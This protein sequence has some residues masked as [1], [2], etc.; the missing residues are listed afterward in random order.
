MQGLT[1][2][3][4]YQVN[5]MNFVKYNPPANVSDKEQCCVRLFQ[6]W[7]SRANVGLECLVLSTHSA[8]SGLLQALSVIFVLST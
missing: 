7:E 3:G 5:L 6:K 1:I 8:I 2:V 4:G